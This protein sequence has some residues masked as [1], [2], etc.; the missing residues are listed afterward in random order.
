MG[1]FEEVFIFNEPDDAERYTETSV[2]DETSPDKDEVEI[3][4]VLETPMYVESEN[5]AQLD[6]EDISEEEIIATE[7]LEDEISEQLSEIKVTEVQSVQPPDVKDTELR[8]NEQVTS[9]GKFLP[10][11]SYTYSQWLH[12]FKHDSAE[13]KNKAEDT[14]EKKEQPKVPETSR[15]FGA[16]M[17]LELEAIDRVVSS[18]K[19]KTEKSSKEISAEELAKKSLELNEGIVSETLA[20]IYE[21]QGSFDKAIRQYVKLSL[22][23]PEKVSFFAARIKELKG[24]K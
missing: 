12:F 10:D 22:I 23:Y 24:K 14:K 13:R 21:E 18:I 4:S 2:Q 17:Q 9:P 8:I 7:F 6:L 15:S 11:K 3:I 1:V 16:T 19:I 20:K 5:I